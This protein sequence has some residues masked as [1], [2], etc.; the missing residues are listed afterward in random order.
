MSALGSRIPTRAI[1]YQRG[2]RGLSRGLPLTNLAKHTQTSEPNSTIYI[3]PFISQKYNKIKGLI[4][5]P[6]NLG[7][8]VRRVSK[9]DVFCN[10]MCLWM[11]ACLS[12][13]LAW[14]STRGEKNSLMHPQHVAF[15][16]LL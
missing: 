9:D 8:N 2:S 12:T 7:A 1:F 14:S 4:L 5:R 13:A 3:Y 16:S 6:L 11:W 15:K 10:G